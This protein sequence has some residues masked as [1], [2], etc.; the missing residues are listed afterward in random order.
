MT[1]HKIL[2]GASGQF[3]KFI[4]YPPDTQWANKP[5]IYVLVDKNLRPLYVGET[6]DLS[7]R[8]P[9]IR[10]PRWKDAAWH[11]ASAV[12]V[13]LASYSEIARRNEE[14]DLVLAYAPICNSQYRPTSLLSRPFSGL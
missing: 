5:A 8:Q 10:H 13:K 3:Y 2:T 12:L 6:G 4:L 14:R 11:G 9:G 1:A 7:S